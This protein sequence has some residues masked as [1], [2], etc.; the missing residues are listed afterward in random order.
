MTPD[1]VKAYA[2]NVFNRDLVHMNCDVNVEP[3]EGALH[4][5]VTPRQFPNQ[6]STCL[7]RPDKPDE[8][9]QTEVVA[10][11]DTMIEMVFTG[12]W[13]RGPEGDA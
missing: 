8:N 3:F 12:A 4:V 10:M 1:E 6:T 2:E 9:F 7:W 13:Q 11:R 5:Q